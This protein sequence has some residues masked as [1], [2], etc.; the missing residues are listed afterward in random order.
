[1]NA[2]IGEKLRRY[3]KQKGYTQEQAADYLK[4]SQSAY[5]RMESGESNSWAV[6]I[7]GICEVF[8][9]S[10]EELL[11][12][13]AVIINNNQQG[14]NSAYFINQVLSEKLIEQYEARLKEK[15]EIIKLL[16]NK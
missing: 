10:P 11:R 14:G 8:E 3:R 12:S 2:I 5:A 9:I 1:M 13:D 4:I 15:D 7:E 6:H 16:K